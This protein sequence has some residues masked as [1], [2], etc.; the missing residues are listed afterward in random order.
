MVNFNSENNSSL[1]ENLEGDSKVLD[2]SQNN[3][4]DSDSLIQ[5]KKY[6]VSTDDEY[7]IQ[8]GI[9]KGS[10]EWRSW[11][12]KKRSNCEDLLMAAEAGNLEQVKS[13]LDK[14]IH[15]EF[16][17]DFRFQGLDDFTALHFSAQEN[18]YD[19]C[20]FLIEKGADLEAKSSIG[21]TSLHLSALRG[22]TEIVELLAKNGADL[23]SRDSDNYTPLH[24]A[25]EMGNVE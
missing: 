11:W 24:Y 22:N 15:N 20:K 25:S 13:L 10:K 8:E 2:F 16:V 4:E 12:K 17:A 6:D 7:L 19:V 21:R 9:T 5:V 18:R 23:N 14:S 3:E 1:K